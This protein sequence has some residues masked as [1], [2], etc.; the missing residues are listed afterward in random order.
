MKISDVNE[1]LIGK[2]VKAIWTGMM[3]TGRVTGMSEDEHCICVYYDM[4]RP[5]VW[6]N[7]TWTNHHA[8][9]RKYDE[10]GSL[11]YMEVIDEMHEIL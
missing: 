5:H 4:E 6:G 7:D 3:V 8:H 9:A 11:K 2:R 10:F 1:A